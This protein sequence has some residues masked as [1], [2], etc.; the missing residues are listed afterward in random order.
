MNFIKLNENVVL[1]E[2]TWFMAHFRAQR[3]MNISSLGIVVDQWYT[4]GSIEFSCTK[5]HPQNIT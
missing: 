1:R 4:S 3:M 5:E 2:I